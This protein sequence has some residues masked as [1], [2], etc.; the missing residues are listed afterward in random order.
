MEEF[1][2]LIAPSEMPNKNLD[3][4]VNAFE[5]IGHKFEKINKYIQAGEEIPLEL[6]KNFG[7]FPLSDDPYSGIE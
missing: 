7:T 4:S 2:T 1:K 3:I 6:T 5:V